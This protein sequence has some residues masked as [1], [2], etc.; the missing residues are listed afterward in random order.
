MAECPCAP[1]EVARVFK[2]PKSIAFIEDTDCSIEEGNVCFYQFEIRDHV[3]KCF[4]CGAVGF[5]RE[6]VGQA[7]VRICDDPLEHK[8][9]AQV[10]K[11]VRLLCEFLKG[12]SVPL[13]DYFII[14]LK[15][16]S[17]TPTVMLCDELVEKPLD[18]ELKGDSLGHITKEHEVVALADNRNVVLLDRR[19]YRQVRHQHTVDFHQV[20]AIA[21]VTFEAKLAVPAILL[22]TEFNRRP[23]QFSGG[24]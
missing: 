19:G 15:Q 14:Y 8:L 11:S 4:K 20:L 6:R 5:E 24:V 23:F 18:E 7:R 22:Y 1:L 21:P 10:V 3:L 2:G 13:L 17:E 12:Q 9:L 16:G